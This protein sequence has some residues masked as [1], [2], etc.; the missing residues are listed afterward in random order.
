MTTTP[1]TLQRLNE[2]REIVASVL[3]VERSQITESS[4]FREDHEADSLRAIEILA[5]LEKRYGIE[6]P[7]E[8]LA[9]M[10]HLAAVYE[11]VKSYA[12]WNDEHH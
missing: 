5:R 8:E 12:G 10:T 2:I 1:A 3:E 11:I 4:R 9:S 6:I 7:Q